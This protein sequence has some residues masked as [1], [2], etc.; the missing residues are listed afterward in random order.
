MAS[1]FKLSYTS[2]NDFNNLNS[3]QNDSESSSVNANILESSVSTNLTAPLKN[4]K[5]SRFIDH[6][7]S[8]EAEL[9]HSS[10]NHHLRNDIK[11]LTTT[12]KS[13]HYSDLSSVKEEDDCKKES[14]DSLA[15]CVNITRTNYY[16]NN[17]E[18][19]NSLKTN[20]KMF[21]GLTMV[22]DFNTIDTTSLQSFSENQLRAALSIYK[23]SPE[24]RKDEIEK[25]YLNSANY[26]LGSSAGSNLLKEF[27]S[28]LMNADNDDCRLR[29]FV[30]QMDFKTSA[31]TSNYQ[32]IIEI[33]NFLG[34]AN[35]KYMDIVYQKLNTVKTWL[36]LI[37]NKYGK[38]VVEEILTNY[39]IYKEYKHFTLFEVIHSNFIEFS[40][41]NYTTFVVQKYIVNYHT[42]QAFDLVESYMED[43]LN[44]R[45]GIF[46]IL[47]SLKSFKKEKV[48][49]L[50]SKIFFKVE[51][52]C[53]GVY[54]S[55]MME[56]VFKTFPQFRVDFI[57]QKL[58]YTLGS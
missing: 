30:A 6:F 57:N 56:F 23:Q 16:E 10:E 11:C 36:E 52:L 2:E 4:Y 14:S 3:T 53:K 49:G 51:T 41:S 45:N 40:K 19:Q 46:V 12:E 33:I 47:T 29:S 7:N 31:L 37:P 8:K 32:N 17:N 42:N 9:S 50:L 35:D 21:P 25:A 26:L 55:T 34:E 22:Q 20:P 38:N 58:E 5:S 54:T 39:Y 48:S 27:C 24:N 15:I 18:P 43:L 28:K 44:N 1:K 13:K